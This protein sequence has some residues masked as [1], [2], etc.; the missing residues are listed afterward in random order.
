MISFADHPV[1]LQH[2]NTRVEFH[3]EEERVAL[4]LTL[5]ADLPN[6][7]LDEISPT[8]RRSLYDADRQAD[9]VDPD[10][11]P[12]LRNPQL[13]TLRWAGRFAGVKLSLR[14]GDDEQMHDLQYADARMDRVRFCPKEGG[15]CS[16]VWH[17]HVLPDDSAFAQTVYFLRR[18]N[19]LGTMSVPDPDDVDES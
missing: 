7:T 18:P 3:G 19:T 12:I 15:T 9:I 8:L 5:K 13:G 16:Y 11:T 14:D 1:T 17:V 6:T 10:N 4:D 2:I